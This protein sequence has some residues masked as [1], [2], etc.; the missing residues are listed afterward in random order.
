M[1]YFSHLLILALLLFRSI[2]FS[3]A[4]D[5]CFVSQ[6]KSVSSDIP[7][8][9][10]SAGYTQKTFESTLSKESIDLSDTRRSGYEW[11]VGQFFGRCST[12]KASFEW[13]GGEFR[14]TGIQ[15][16]CNPVGNAHISTAV[17]RPTGKDWV[18]LAFGG[19]AYIEATLS[20]DPDNTV[21]AAKGRQ[22]P[23]FWAMSIE[24]LAQ[25]SEEQWK[26]ATPGYKH[27]IE[28]DIF[29]YDVWEF[30][31]KKSYGG[32]VHD[33]YGRY[34]DTCPKPHYCRVTNAKN[35]GTRFDNFIITTPPRTDFKKAHKYGVLWKPA[36][37]NKSGT[38]QYY[39]DRI[40]LNDKVDWV[41]FEN[42]PPPPGEA[43]WTFGIID[44]QHLALVLSS[45]I[46]QPLTVQNVSV[47]QNNRCNNWYK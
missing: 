13:S 25:L 29:E 8:P 18:G 17:D 6:E 39:F 44:E 3:V 46:D 32:A 1:R 19:G 30:A 34:R 16:E 22:W 2:A 15:N 33:W 38:L 45:G 23:A 47:W 4:A 20:F 43:N 5:D 9:A 31:G 35:S 10:K 21:R 42:Q 27:F 36:S 24:H 7:E 14:L 12:S 37:P 11:Y 40:P 41:K 26:G 28:V